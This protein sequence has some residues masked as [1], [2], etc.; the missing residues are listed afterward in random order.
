MVGGFATRRGSVRPRNARRSRRV[1]AAISARR[2]CRSCRRSTVGSSAG[3]VTT[4]FARSR[5][6]RRRRPTISGFPTPCVPWP[7]VSRPSIISGSGCTSSRTCTRRPAPT[8]ETI[9]AMYDGAIARLDNAVTDLG[10]PLAYTPALPPD[11][12]LD[13][14]PDVQ[15]QLRNGRVGGSGQRCERTHPRRRHLSSRALATLRSHR[16]RSNRSTCIACSGW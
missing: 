7:G 5:T 10:K 3:W 2:R 4:P 6:F 16:S 8:T 14:L 11:D 12:D 13:Q 9:D 1:A 15:Q